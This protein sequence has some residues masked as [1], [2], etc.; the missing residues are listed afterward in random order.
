VKPEPA[1]ADGEVYA[2]TSQGNAELKSAGTSLSSRELEVLVLV[3][4]VATAGQIARASP[5]MPQAE[6]MQV[7]QKLAAMQLIAPASGP[8]AQESEFFSIIVPPGVFS[9]GAGNEP[10]AKQG[11]ASLKR[12]GYYVRI[13]RRAPQKRAAKEGWQPTILVID[14]DADLVKLIRTY[15]RFEGFVVRNAGRRAEIMAAFRE[16]PM[17]DLVLLDV[18]L[19]DANGFDVLAR[20]RQHAVL[21]SIPVIMITAEATRESVRNGLQAGA[22][23][24]IT[25]PFEPDCV[26]TAVQEVLGLTQ[27]KPKPSRA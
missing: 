5:T 11:V 6:V 1:P 10:E 25:K 26:V 21:K 27:E 8:S 13:A 3:D 24:Y 18:E 17:P 7:L 22:D 23:G 4:G 15:F 14:D 12:K 9:S 20:M 2:P 19:P 16:P